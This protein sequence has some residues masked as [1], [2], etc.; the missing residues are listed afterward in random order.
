MS[1][2]TRDSGRDFKGEEEE[3]GRARKLIEMEWAK[4]GKGEWQK[5][6]AEG[7]PGSRPCPDPGWPPGQRLGQKAGCTNRKVPEGTKAPPRG[8]A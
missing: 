6:K 2:G 7:P 3:M 8:H 1:G 4:A 5:L